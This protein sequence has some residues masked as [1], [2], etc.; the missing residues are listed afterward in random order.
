MFQIWVCVF[1]ARI[2]YFR[3]AH[4]ITVWKYFLS[5]EQWLQRIAWRQVVNKC[6]KVKKASK[7]M[8]ECDMWL[9]TYHLLCVLQR[10]KCEDWVDL[11]VKRLGE[12]AL[13]KWRLSWVEEE[14]WGAGMRGG[15]CQKEERTPRGLTAGKF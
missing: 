11:S 2:Q 12:V 6:K 3:Y 4:G 15:D 13:R 5:M 9:S 8:K 7:K 14:A 10:N 1:S